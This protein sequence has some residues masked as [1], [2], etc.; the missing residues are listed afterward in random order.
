MTG[1]IVRLLYIVFRVEHVNTSTR[2][3]NKGIYEISLPT[4]IRPIKEDVKLDDRTPSSRGSRG[5][6]TIQ[7]TGSDRK[8]GW[9][10]DTYNK[11][12]GGDEIMAQKGQGGGYGSWDR[13]YRQSSVPPIS[14]SC[15]PLLQ[16]GSLSGWDVCR[17]IMGC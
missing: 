12:I 4:S 5:G 14:P 1:C 3:I 8:W 15:S 13:T 16:A 10:E 6:W 9:E 7:A 2:Q 17:G 11:D